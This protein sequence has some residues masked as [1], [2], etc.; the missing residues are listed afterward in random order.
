MKFPTLEL[1]LT[2]SLVLH[3]TML[4]IHFVSPQR[5]QLHNAGL[6][7]VLVNSRSDQRPK[8][9]QVLAQ[10]NQDGGG[11]V[12]ENRIASSP[13]P[14][15]LREQSGAE[16]EQRLRRQ[17]EALEAERR[18][19]TARNS[20]QRARIN[21]IVEKTE[22]TH[23]VLPTDGHDL[24]ESMRE[25]ARLRAQ[26]ARDHEEF[27]KRPRRNNAG[28]RAM[29]IVSAQYLDA[30][31]QKVERIGTL[32][33]PSSNKGRISGSLILTVA[34]T[35]EGHVHEVVIKES[36]GH[37]V[38]D[39]AALRIVR[40]ASPYPPLPPAILETTDILEITREW[41]FT[42]EQSLET[43]AASAPSP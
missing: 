6:D 37:K 36:S 18:L 31:R 12:D 17:N 29:R 8:D 10:H 23:T 9:V 40:M 33:Y 16:L 1:A 21:E 34:I 28:V 35:R 3:G 42:P 7:V 27:N 24:A 2:V 32:N 19:L 26:V 38:L 30:W 14:P 22:A 43:S 13:L 15:T 20:R 41:K 4:S 25:L 5:P 11:T 39:D